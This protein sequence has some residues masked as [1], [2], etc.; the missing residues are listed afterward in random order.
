[1]FFLS[2]QVPISV[3]YNCKIS[4]KRKGLS[5]G[6]GGNTSFT[7]CDF[8]FPYRTVTMLS[9]NHLPLFCEANKIIWADVVMRIKSGEKITGW[10]INGNWWK[11]FWVKRWSLLCSIM[12]WHTGEH[13]LEDRITNFWSLWYCQHT[14][15]SPNK[16]ETHPCIFF[17]HHIPV[18]W[19]MVQ[20]PDKNSRYLKKYMVGQYGNASQP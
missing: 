14:S 5:L 13:D 2:L 17:F 3:V 7:R 6:F 19:K 12:I 1:M 8:M 11:L 9:S 18:T 20:W 16:T 15:K 4:T 10:A